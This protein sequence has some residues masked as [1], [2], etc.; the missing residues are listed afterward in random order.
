MTPLGP[1]FSLGRARAGMTV[2]IAWFRR[3][4]IRFVQRLLLPSEPR[5]SSVQAKLA[6]GGSDAVGATRHSPFA[7]ARTG[8]PFATGV[9]TGVG[10]GLRRAAAL[11]WLLVPF[12]VPVFAVGAMGCAKTYIVN[13]DVE[14]TGENLKI[15]VFCETYRNAVEAKNIGLLLKL[16]SPRY[17]EDGGNIN[18]GDDLDYDG[19]KDYLTSTF[20]KTE[21][22][23]Y[24]IRYRKVTFSP[25][26]HI[27]VDYTY[28]GSYRLP[29]VKAE[30]WKH[31]VADNR[32]DL[33]PDGE[34]YK[35]VSGM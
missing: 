6:D 9:R 8:G 13:T 23:R 15:I 18:G 3:K 21:D 4:M 34:T 24:E 32:L 12:A 35:I 1:S 10:V 30:E 2:A 25:T 27:Y 20:M 5:E 29:G 16:A 19:L 33:V 17:H 28:A 22:V 7:R 14:D 11:S 26:N 31:T